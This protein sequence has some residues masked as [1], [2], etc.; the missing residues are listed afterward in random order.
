MAATKHDFARA[1][2]LVAAI[3][4][5]ASG[6]GLLFLKIGL[7]DT[8][9]VVVYLLA[10]QV[11]VW[12]TQSLALGLGASVLATFLF[13]YFFAEPIFAFSVEDPNYVVTLVVMA[14][15]ALV[16]SI[17][18]THTQRSEKAAREKEEEM[19]ALYSLTNH[20]TDAGDFH[21]IACVAV[22]SISECFRCR[23]GCLCF[24]EYGMP[25]PAFVQQLSPK[26]QIMRELESRLDM[27]HRIDSLRTG[28]DAGTEFYDWPIYGKDSVLGVL[29]IPSQSAEG[30]VEQDMRLLRA[31]IENV[32]LAMDRFRSAEQ[33]MKTR[34]EIIGERYRS[35]LLRSISHDLRTPLAG[36]TGISEMLMGMTEQDDPR[37]ALA[38]DIYRDAD[39]LRSMVENILNLTRIQDSGLPLKKRSEALEEVVGG[40]VGR[41]SSRCPE[42]RFAVSVPDELIFIPMDIKLIEQV[43]INLLDNAVKQ[44]TPGDEISILA[45]LSPA[46]SEVSFKIRDS[47]TGIRP[48][49]LPHLFEMFYSQPTG[50]PSARQGIGLGLTICQTIVRAHGGRIEGRNRADGNGA[51]FEFT[52]PLDEEEERDEAIQ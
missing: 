48:D 25:E 30:L 3:F 4:L 16:T 18:I 52:L 23:A 17:I 43:I 40:A 26:K 27:K 21:E 47:G 35:T 49:V 28:Y 24:D 36:I 50:E 45:E 2:L 20:L 34:E 33:K 8:N 7:P 42:Y 10:V 41:V 6:I 15:S 22:S 32:A 31:M 5:A 44:S 9:I 14:I 19:K 38:S 12:L 39:W 29:R 37:H 46:K 13:Y 11:T 51:E 1:L